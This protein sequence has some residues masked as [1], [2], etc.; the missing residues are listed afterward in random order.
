M[1]KVYNTN[2]TE[3]SVAYAKSPSNFQ[4][5][6]KFFPAL[7]IFPAIWGKILEGK[8]FVKFGCYTQ[9]SGARDYG[10]I[11]ISPELMFIM[12]NW[13]SFRGR[14]WFV[15]MA[16]IGI[17]IVG[18]IIIF[19]YLPAEEKPEIV[20]KGWDKTIG[21]WGGSMDEC[22]QQTS[23]G[24]YITVANTNITF[25]ET[26]TGEIMNFSLIK[27]DEDGN[28]LWTKIYNPGDPSFE[29]FTGCSVQ[30]T[31]DGGYVTVATV[32]P[33]S[34]KVPIRIVSPDTKKPSAKAY[35]MK[36]DQNGNK[37]WESYIGE[38]YVTGY[39]VQQASDGGYAIL[40]WAPDGEEGIYLAKTD[41]LGKMTWQKNF[42]RGPKDQAY[43]LKL[44]SDGGYVIAGRSEILFPVGSRPAAQED[45]YIVKTDADGN[46]LWEKKYAEKADEIWDARSI[47]ET[48]DGGY[49]VVGSIFS[50]TFGGH[51][52]RKID[53]NGNL[54]WEK[55]FSIQSYPNPSFYSVQQTSDG[56]Y[57]IAGGIGVTLNGKHLLPN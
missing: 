3:N 43:S 38:G 51:Y 37:L 6:P 50:G 29:Y 31:A 55:M 19:V 21:G 52:L 23:D 48:S 46:K 1:E 39:S 7:K 47:Q 5:F 8:N 4:N 44:T 20:G 17:V 30:Q 24:G 32:F 2:L 53:S 57:I 45:A 11:I 41:A 49:I 18:L 14:R 22:I 15:L 54:V 13:K 36:T 25:A 35:L 40:G 56:G 26:F 34:E 10:K 42:G 16:V 33:A 9:V 27:M 12:M 28:V